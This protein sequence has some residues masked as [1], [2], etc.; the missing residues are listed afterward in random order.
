MYRRE[1]LSSQTIQAYVAHGRSLQAEALRAAFAAVFR[2]VVRVV[3][4][5][6]AVRCPAFAAC[7]VCPKRCNTSPVS[8]HGRATRP[9]RAECPLYGYRS[10]A[11]RSLT[12]LA[13]TGLR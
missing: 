7:G 3:T 10:R 11:C 8:C 13:R 2:P 4:G 12:S 5:L 9:A 6:A 1:T